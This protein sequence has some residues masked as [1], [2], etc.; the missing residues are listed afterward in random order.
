M[1]KIKTI[2]YRKVEYK[3]LT[4]KRQITMKKNKT[5]IYRKLNIEIV[6]RK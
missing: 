4:K 5:L 1:E 6:S 2:I 3:I